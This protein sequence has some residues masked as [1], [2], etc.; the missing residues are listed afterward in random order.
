MA[1]VTPKSYMVGQIIDVKIW[2]DDES[3]PPLSDRELKLECALTEIVSRG[4]GTRLDYMTQ[5]QLF[6]RRLVNG[7]MGDHGITAKP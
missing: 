7:Q 3:V 6:H 1:Y 4:F 5:T 2:N